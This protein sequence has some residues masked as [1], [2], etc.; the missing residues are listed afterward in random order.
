[1]AARSSK[2]TQSDL[3]SLV[4]SAGWKEDQR[5]SNSCA[6][7]TEIP[8]RTFLNQASL[9]ADVRLPKNCRDCQTPLPIT[10]KNSQEAGR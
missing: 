2:K 3:I 9:L 5:T 7:D 10:T 6:T 4:K 8:A 1:M